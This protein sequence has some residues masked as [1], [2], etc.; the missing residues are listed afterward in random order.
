MAKGIKSKKNN[1]RNDKS[2][3]RGV[4]RDFSSTSIKDSSV[5]DDVDLGNVDPQQSS[6]CNFKFILCCLFKSY[7]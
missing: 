1:D 7:N 6:S 5:Y 4:S 2:V 3:S